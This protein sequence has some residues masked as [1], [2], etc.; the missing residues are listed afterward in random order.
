MP[1]R[2]RYGVPMRNRL[3]C[4][5][6]TRLTKYAHAEDSRPTLLDIEDV[7]EDA[8]GVLEERALPDLVPRPLPVVGQGGGC[9]FLSMSG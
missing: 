7:L 4:V 3:G 9:E 8:D 5:S 2:V 6:A 1:S